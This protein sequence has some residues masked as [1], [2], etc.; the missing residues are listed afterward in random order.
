MIRVREERPSDIEAIRAIHQ[1]AFPTPVESVLVDRL[2]EHEKAVISLVA[3][4]DGCVCG[5][6]LFSPVTLHSLS[7]PLVGLGLA[8]VAVL[9]EYRRRG[10]GSRLI[11]TGLAACKGASCPFVVLIG[12]PAYYR[13][14]GFETASRYHLANEY[15][16]DEPFM[17]VILRPDAVPKEGGMVK[18]SV[19]FANLE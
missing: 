12:E 1:S 18:Y 8:P 13:R 17:A 10:I 16:V 9:S 14:F 5:H 7:G 3:E 4:C 6:V 2:R 19:D 11:E 15:G